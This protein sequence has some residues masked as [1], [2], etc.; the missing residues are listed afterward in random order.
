M[1]LISAF[2]A[3][4]VYAEE[5]LKDNR[6][7]EGDC[8]CSEKR[9][10]QVTLTQIITVTPNMESEHQSYKKSPLSLNSSFLNTSCDA[11]H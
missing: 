3:S 9:S 1:Y 10:S 7:N 2:A 8:R 11:S 6:A 5:P 4:Q